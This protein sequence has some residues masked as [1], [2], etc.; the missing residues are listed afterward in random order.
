MF[1]PSEWRAL[2]SKEKKGRKRDELKQ[3][4]VQTVEKLFNKKV[5]DD[6][7]DAILIAQAL[8]NKYE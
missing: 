2:I 3:W 1:R 6:E 4:S 5:N 8:V 7:A